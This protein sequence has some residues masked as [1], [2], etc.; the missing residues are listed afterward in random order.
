MEYIYR[1]VFHLIQYPVS[2]SQAGGSTTGYSDQ[3]LP[4][5]LP[6]ILDLVPLNMEVPVKSS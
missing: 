2:Y 5:I 3:G 4:P 1:I 6:G